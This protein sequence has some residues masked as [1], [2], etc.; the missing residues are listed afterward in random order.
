ME[1]SHVQ[2]RRYVMRHRAKDERQ[3]SEMY[4]TQEGHQFEHLL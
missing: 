4:I 1:Y 2:K 3:K